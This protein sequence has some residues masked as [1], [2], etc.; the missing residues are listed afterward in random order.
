[1]KRR[2]LLLIGIVMGVLSLSG[3]GNTTDG[4]NTTQSSVASSESS[5]EVSEEDNAPSEESSAPEQETESVENPG[6]Q[7]SDSE[8]VAALDAIWNGIAEDEKF[9]CYGGNVTNPVDGAPGELDVTDADSLT[10]TLLIPEGIQS[11]VEAA[12]DLVH[13]MNAN[14]FTSAAVKV[15]SDQAGFIEQLSDGILQT[16][17]MCGMPDRLVIMSYGDTVI[18]TFGADELVVQFKDS[19][20]NNLE[21]V[22]VEVDQLFE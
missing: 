11:S 17:F 19:A 22:K 4:G 10:Y 16:Q 13:F 1:M 20:N 2:N 14:T 12:A 3:C 5:V 7:Q 9:P 8:V 15:S 18:Y 6:N 21:G